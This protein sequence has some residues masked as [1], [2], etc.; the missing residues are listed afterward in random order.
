MTEHETNEE[1]TATGRITGVVAAVTSDRELIINRGSEHGVKAGMTF[2][3]R[4]QP[5]PIEDPETR[6]VIGEVNPVKVMVRVAEVQPR[7]AIAR[8]FR[9][10]RVLVEAAQSAG[11]L[12]GGGSSSLANLLQPP[13][14]A[15]YEQRIETLRRDPKKGSPISDAD[16]VVAVG[17]PVI[18]ML[19][20]DDL[21]A[22]TTT[23]LFQ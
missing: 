23:T 2:V 5:T 10:E 9:S 13:R 16:S 8:T 15:K 22:A 18:E 6:E 3:V 4:G 1:S 12:Y 17:D 7:L 19:D 11:A 20:G 21:N 14:P